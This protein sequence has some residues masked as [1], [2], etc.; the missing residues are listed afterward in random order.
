M[1]ATELQQTSEPTSATKGHHRQSP[2]A[3]CPYIDQR[4]GYICA[5]HDSRITRRPIQFAARICS[6]QCARNPL[7]TACAYRCVTRQK[8]TIL[9]IFA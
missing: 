6:Q 8:G 2:R 9:A 3:H 7:L 5:A 1:R 4:R